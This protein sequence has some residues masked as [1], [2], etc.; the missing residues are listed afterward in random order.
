MV[1]NERKLFRKTNPKLFLCT[2]HDCS[3]LESRHS[4]R[5]PARTSLF[6]SFKIAAVSSPRLSHFSKN[7]SPAVRICCGVGQLL[8]EDRGR[9]D[10][11]RNGR[12][13]SAKWRQE[14][15]RKLVHFPYRSPSPKQDAHHQICTR[16]LSLVSCI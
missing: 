8:V 13:V 10:N 15:E 11:R 16:L 1:V 6:Q 2:I 12:F 14:S 9:S 5:S 3:R 4:A 7:R